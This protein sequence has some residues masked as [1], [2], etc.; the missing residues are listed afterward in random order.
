MVQIVRNKDVR[1]WSWVEIEF[2]N[3]QTRGNSGGGGGGLDSYKRDP[4]SLAYTGVE[5]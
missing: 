2:P 4:K 3:E 1:L 5:E